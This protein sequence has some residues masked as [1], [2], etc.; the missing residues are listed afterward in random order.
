M[1]VFNYPRSYSALHDILYTQSHNGLALPDWITPDVY[2][3]IRY[4]A[5]ATFHMAAGVNNR[6]SLHR[7]RMRGGNMLRVIMENLV[8]RSNDSEVNADVKLFFYSAV[9]SSRAWW[10]ISFCFLVHF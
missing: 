10:N 7:Q 6:S 1:K 4:M 3:D 8:R 9:R 5:D 2:R